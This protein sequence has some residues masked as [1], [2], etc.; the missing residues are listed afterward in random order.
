MGSYEKYDFI[1]MLFNDFPRRSECRKSENVFVLD[2]SVR[3]RGSQVIA[4]CCDKYI[5]RIKSA[6]FATNA[7]ALKHPECNAGLLQRPSP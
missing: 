5:C 3:S 1:F 4:M 2:F 7:C 6:L